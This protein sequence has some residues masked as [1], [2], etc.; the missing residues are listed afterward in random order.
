MKKS[1]LVALGAVIALWV[2][3]FVLVES[4]LGGVLK[5]E[6]GMMEFWPPLMGP[7]LITLLGNDK[8]AE[9]NFYITGAVGVLAAFLFVEL[10][11]M[12]V[13]FMGADL[14]VLTAMFL[15]VFAVIFSGFVVPSVSGPVSFIY[16]NAGT[17]L[18]SNILPRT[19][20]RLLLMIVGTYIFLHVEHTLVGLISG[21]KHA[22]A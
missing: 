10:E 1:K 17:V 15:I 19:V 18:T 11:H 7:S 14:G 20:I 22:D 3:I 2:T 4:L 21:K 6:A 9:K 5:L 13:P 8:K 16:F 12:L